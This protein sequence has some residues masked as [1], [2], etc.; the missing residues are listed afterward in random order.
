MFKAALNIVE[1]YFKLHSIG[2]S[3]QDLNEGSFF[4]NP[5][6]GDVL[7]C[8][9]DN[10]APFGVNLGVRGIPKYMAPEV[11]LNQSYPNTHTDRFSLAIILF[12]LFYIDH[13]LEGQYTIQFPLTD[14]IG[15][16]LFGENP[17]FVYDPN[18]PSNRPVPEAQPN[19]IERWH[20]FPPDLNAAFTKAFTAGLKDIN[21]RITELQWREVLVKARGMLV[22]IDGKEQFVNAYQP[23]SLPKGCRLLH[24]EEQIIA[25]APNSVLYPCQIDKFSTDY[26]SPAALVRASNSNSNIYGLGN[27]TS[28]DWSITVPGKGVTTIQPKGFA[29]LIPGVII[30]F[31]NV[32]GKVF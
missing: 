13:P 5:S 6:N 18:N 4:I 27:L 12:R 10:V 17:V 2:Y 1:S 22:C 14:A 25:L 8:D 30:D 21:S 26:L 16:R 19:V 29:P 9:N 28:Q 11:V 23:N 3:Y 20:M 15:A 24:T 7:I 31:G 32:K